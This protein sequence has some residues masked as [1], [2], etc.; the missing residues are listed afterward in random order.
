MGC[1]VVIVVVVGLFSF[2]WLFWDVFVVVA[3]FVCFVFVFCQVNLNVCIDM[4][5][6]SLSTVLCTLYVNLIPIRVY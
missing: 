1:F 5:Q 3:G 2:C 6:Y 4:T